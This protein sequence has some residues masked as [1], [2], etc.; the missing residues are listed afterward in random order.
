[1]SCSDR[2][3]V[4][5]ID[6]PDDARIVSTIINLAHGLDLEVVAE[7][8]ENGE[9]LAFLRQRGCALG[10]GYLFSPPVPAEAFN[11]LLLDDA[12]AKAVQTIEGLLGVVPAI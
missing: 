7:G 1:M 9:Q 12:S 5:D 4:S 6:D 2:S 10:Q 8:I 3:F 11:K